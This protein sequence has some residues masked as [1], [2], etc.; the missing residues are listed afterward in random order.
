MSA[1]RNFSAISWVWVVLLAVGCGTASS[2]ATGSPA[3]EGPASAVSGPKIG[4][5]RA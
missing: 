1:R 2:H 5:V 3:A 4:G